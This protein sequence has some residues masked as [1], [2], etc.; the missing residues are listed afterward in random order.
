M[1]PKGSPL[2]IF[3]HYTTFFERKKYEVFFQK[4]FLLPIEEKVISQSYQ[5][6]K[7]H[8]GCHETVFKA[9]HEYVIFNQSRIC[10]NVVGLGLFPSDSLQ[11]QLYEFIEIAY[12][13]PYYGVEN[14]SRNFRSSR[15]DAQFLQKSK[16]SKNG[17]FLAI[18]G[19]I[20]AVS[21]IPAIRF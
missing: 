3:R 1:N 17:C 13:G 21:H 7:A 12:I 16:K 2:F 11:S 20:S 4:L 8:Y 14:F 10:D 19:L 9:F 5:A 18:F 6:C 15:M